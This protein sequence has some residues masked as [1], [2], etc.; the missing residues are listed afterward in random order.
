MV[1]RRRRVARCSSRRPLSRRASCAHAACG[2]RAGR[3][4]RRP[5]RAPRGA[6]YSNYKG[7]VGPFRPARPGR[8]GV[9]LELGAAER[10]GGRVRRARPPPAS[11]CAAPPGT[12]KGREGGA[13]TRD[14]PRAAQRHRGRGR[15]PEGP[16]DLGGTERRG[17]RGRGRRRSRFRPGPG[18]SL[19]SAILI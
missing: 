18:V 3:V 12:G 9:W 14:A 17:R 2:R 11:P 16:P 13:G 8:G 5:G 4:L 1:A 15:G 10:G 19:I 7:G 6:L